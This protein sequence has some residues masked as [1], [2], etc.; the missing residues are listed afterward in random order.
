[1]TATPGASRSTAAN[2]S[3]GLANDTTSPFYNNTAGQKAETTMNKAAWGKDVNFKGQRSSITSSGDANV[4]ISEPAQPSTW[5]EAQKSNV[6]QV[7]A[8]LSVDESVSRVTQSDAQLASSPPKRVP[9]PPST[10]I[11][12]NLANGQT[13]SC[14]MPLSKVQDALPKARATA[15]VRPASGGEPFHS[16][17][18]RRQRDRQV[19]PWA[20]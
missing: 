13:L 12:S 7:E 9:Q 8:G 10:L 2:Y 1:M 15:W 4:G 19:A 20:D 3:S 11:D 17:V 14:E 16:I 6:K 5:F 18:Q